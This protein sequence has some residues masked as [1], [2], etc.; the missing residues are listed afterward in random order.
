MDVARATT[1][2]VHCFSINNAKESF[3]SFYPRWIFIDAKSHFSLRLLH[4]RTKNIVR[5]RGKNFRLGFAGIPSGF[6]PDYI[7]DKRAPSRPSGGSGPI[8]LESF[9]TAT[10]LS[11]G[12]SFGPVSLRKHSWERRKR[13]FFSKLRNESPKR[14]SSFPLHAN[15]NPRRDTLSM[16]TPV[17]VC[18][19]NIF[20]ARIW[21]TGSQLGC[22]SNPMESSRPTLRYSGVAFVRLSVFSIARARPFHRFR[23][24]CAERGGVWGGSIHFEDERSCKRK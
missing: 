5:E 2:D 21:K 12:F 7:P 22:L 4:H 18:L 13:I 9:A 20:L 15:D 11:P 14:R 17:F 19:A 3:F 24:V 8:M 6:P 1:R 10:Q 16:D 23:L